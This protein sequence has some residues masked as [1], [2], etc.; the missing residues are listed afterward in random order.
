MDHKQ[1]KALNKRRIALIDK[2]YDRRRN[3]LSKDEEKELA[4]LQ[5]E[6]ADYLHIH[7][8]FPKRMRRR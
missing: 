5:Q 6:A 2:K 7:S 4:R 1:W 8:P 3:G